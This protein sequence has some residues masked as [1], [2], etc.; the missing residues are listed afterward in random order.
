[1]LNPRWLNI[2]DENP[3]QLSITN[4]R[5]KQTCMYTNLLSHTQSL[6]LSIIKLPTLLPRLTSFLSLLA[7]SWWLQTRRRIFVVTLMSRGMSTSITFSWS[8]VRLSQPI[9]W[10]LTYLPY[11]TN[12]ITRYTEIHIMST[13]QW[14]TFIWP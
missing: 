5:Y 10:Y 2:L 11:L 13:M 3:E 6:S 4:W 8:M 7:S 14:W 12:W 1:M 9:Y